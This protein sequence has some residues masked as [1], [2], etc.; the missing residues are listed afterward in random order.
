MYIMYTFC[1]DMSVGESVV[2]VVMFGHKLSYNK[3]LLVALWLQFI[4]GQ[5]R[6]N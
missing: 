3:C 4:M 1:N 5:P 6:G 2:S